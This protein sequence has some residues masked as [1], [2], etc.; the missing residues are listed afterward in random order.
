[1][2]LSGQDKLQNTFIYLIGFPGTGKYTIAQEIARKADF[3]LVDNHLINNPVFSLI[4]VDGKTKLPERT[5]DNTLKIW[6]VVADTIVHISPREYNFVLTNS[7]IQGDAA[8]HRHYER[9]KGIAEQREGRF[10]PV[11]LIISDIEEHVKR[12]T[13]PSRTLKLKQTD[14]ESPQLY[15]TTREVLHVSHPNGLTLDVTRLT[16]QEAADIILKH[17]ISAKAGE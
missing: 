12:I 11:R 13:A 2:N 17:A 9:T 15:A 1:M 3:R 7:L 10:I 4:H 6:E 8:D 14:A 5:W 16:A